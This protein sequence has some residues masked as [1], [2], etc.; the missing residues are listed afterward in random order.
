MTNDLRE[1]VDKWRAYASLYDPARTDTFNAR[2]E[3][4]ESAA[5]Q[6]EEVLDENEERRPNARVIDMPWGVKDD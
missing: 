1:L 6:L 5:D 3:T 4:W 2:C